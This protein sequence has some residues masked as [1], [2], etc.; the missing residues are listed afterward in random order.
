M[1]HRNKG[2]QNTN[3]SIKQTN[4]LLP[5]SR[6]DENKEESPPKTIQKIKTINDIF[7]MDDKKRSEMETKLY[8]D[9]L[10]VINSYFNRTIYIHKA[11]KSVEI[12][13]YIPGWIHD[14]YGFVDIESFYLFH[15]DLLQCYL[16]EKNLEFKLPSLDEYIKERHSRRR[17]RLNIIT[18]PKNRSKRELEQISS[19]AL[20]NSLIVFNN[21]IVEYKQNDRNDTQNLIIRADSIHNLPFADKSSLSFEDIVEI[22]LHFCQQ[23]FSIS[24]TIQNKKEDIIRVCNGKIDV[25]KKLSDNDSLQIKYEERVEVVRSDQKC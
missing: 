20:L 25:V 13:A 1:P 5:Y 11:P 23:L 21:A 22:G 14:E 7:N 9:G 6:D 15:R 19:N 12:V 24:K 16:E 18:I 3:K 10:I 4:N 17:N 2:K 8:L